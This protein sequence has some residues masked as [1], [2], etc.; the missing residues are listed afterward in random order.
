MKFSLASSILLASSPIIITTHGWKTNS[1]STKFQP[2]FHTPGVG[3]VGYT[4][5]PN[6]MFYHSPSD[7]YH[8]FWQCSLD[9]DRAVTPIVWCHAISKDFAKWER[10]E[11]QSAMN[12]S[13]G[14][15]QT[16]SG[17]VKMLYKDTAKANAFY[18]ASPE[19]LT[20]PRLES[21]VEDVNASAIGGSTDPSPGW[22]N[23]DETGFL[24]VVGANVGANGSATLWSADEEFGNFVNLEKM[25]LSFPWDRTGKNDSPIPRD[26]NFFK[27]QGDSGLWAFEGAMKM[28]YYA[29]H[30]FYAL[31]TY[32]EVEMDF[33]SS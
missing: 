14:A 12:Y 33:A 26:P 2:I 3:S 6:G 24:A 17:D 1:I 13:G 9:I 16:R 7:T 30:D 10:L 23:A 32:D 28:C 19:D 29:G 18:T 8:L 5:D 31:G 25:L 15:T 21:W 11:A 20:D 4:G 22:W 27:P